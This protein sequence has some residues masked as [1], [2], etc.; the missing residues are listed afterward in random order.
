[1]RK[2][3]LL[4]KTLMVTA[5]IVVC[6]ALV[7][8]LSACGEANKAV[9]KTA[10]TNDLEQL[11]DPTSDLWRDAI[12]SSGGALSAEFVSAW[13][14]GYSFEVGEISIEGT[15]AT[16]QVSITCKQLFPVMLSAQEALLNDE[17]LAEITEDELLQKVEEAFIA[18]LDKAQP[19]TTEFEVTCE[20]IDNVWEPTAQATAEF[21]KALLGSE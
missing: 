10:L 14:K 15:T 12:D 18:E 9:I 19:A 6:F 5:A 20:L 3:A 2:I 1:M 4:R 11:K 17:G 21:E 13:S 7:L 16:A 8:T